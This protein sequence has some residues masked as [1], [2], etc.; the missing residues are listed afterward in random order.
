[1]FPYLDGHKLCCI[2]HWGGCVFVN[3]GFLRVYMPRSGIAGSYGRSPAE[4]FPEADKKIRLQCRRPG[5]DPWVG[6]IPQRRDTL[7]TPVFLSFLCGSAGK[8]PLQCGRAGFDPWAGKIPWRRERLPTPVFFPGESHGLY[9][10]Q[11]C[12]TSDTPERGS[13]S[14]SN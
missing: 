6:K 1:M 8:I 7:P 12:N 11:G 3:Y 5:F 10:P 13:L 9:S 4:G 14:L 2:E